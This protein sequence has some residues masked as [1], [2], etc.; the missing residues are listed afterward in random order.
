VYKIKI[1]VLTGQPEPV[2]GFDLTSYYV[3][4]CTGKINKAADHVYNIISCFGDNRTA[5]KRPE[6]VAVSGSDKAVRSNRSHRFLWDHICPSV[7]EY[8]AVL[9]NLITET[10]KADVSGIHLDC[11]GFPRSEYCTCKR[12]VEGSRES[13]LGWFEWRSKVVSDFVGEASKIVKENGKSFSVTLLPD[14]CFGKE[15]YGQD[16]RSISNY[17]DFFLVPL[18]DVA[19][20]TTYWLE[21][22]AYDFSKQLKKPLYIELYAANPKLQLKN[23]L[24]AIIAVS[25]HAD[26]V[27]L[28]THNSTLSKEIQD[29]L[30]K[31]IEFV[32][33]LERRGCESMIS[34][35]RKWK[36]NN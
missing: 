13:K 22:L 6:W 7:E 25:N 1:G 34:I 15:R 11:I 21:T 32:Q 9:F 16:F 12:C 14:P 33:F 20:S 4:S 3:K 36:E 26:G 2:N 29:T 30:V 10:L 17:V 24:A 19:Y 27:I 23:L 18:Y 31:N 5:R 8:K 35:I 28:A